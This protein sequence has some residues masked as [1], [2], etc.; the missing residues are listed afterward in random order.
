MC[1][2]SY[3]MRAGFSMITAIFVIVIMAAIGA[4]VMNLS[5]KIV[6][7]TTSQYRQEQAILYAKSYTEFAIMAATAT[8]CIKKIAS[9]VDGNTNEVLQGQ[10][11]RVVA[12]ISY[13]GGCPASSSS[14]TTLNSKA[15]IITV[16]TYVHYRDP[17]NPQA[18]TNI[19]WS[20][21]PG[22]TYHRRTIQR[23]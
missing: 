9:N 3:N 22:F 10:G 17:D 18:K 5:G 7:E 4:F 23:L 1:F 19:P 14:I 6:Q 11:Y 20:A 2:K 13:V 8:N 21:Y 12:K 15:N 16:D